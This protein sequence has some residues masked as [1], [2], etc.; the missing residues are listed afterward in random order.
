MSACHAPGNPDTVAIDTTKPRTRRIFFAL[1]PEAPLAHTLYGLAQEL[2]ARQG[3]RCM[4]EN[5][6]HLTLAFL[7]D[8]PVDHLEGARRAA[9]DLQHEVFALQLDRLNHW[10]HNRIAWAGCS[11]PPVA[12]MN[13]ADA[14]QNRLRQAG[15]AIESRPFT[16]H[17]TLLRNCRQATA[18]ALPPLLW[19]A[20]EFVL[21]ESLSPENRDGGGRYRTIGHWPLSARSKKT[22]G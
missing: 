8:I 6:L 16:P 10:P 17:V 20:R 5:S 15:F 12:L 9:D 14:L 7:G 4:D 21:V 11:E 22:S 18:V 13:L 19:P 3:G 2:A 1:W